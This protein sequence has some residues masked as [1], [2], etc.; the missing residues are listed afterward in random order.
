MYQIEIPKE[1][2]EHG[3]YKT[4][5]EIKLRHMGSRGVTK[6]KVITRRRSV[7]RRNIRGR[8]TKRFY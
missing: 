5:P 6:Y 8:K 7:E 2:G 4:R 1:D 3:W